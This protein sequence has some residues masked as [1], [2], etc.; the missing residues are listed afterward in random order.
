MKAGERNAN[1]KSE[2]QHGAAPHLRRCGAMDRAEREDPEHHLKGTTEIEMRF[3]M[4]GPARM[5]SR[6]AVIRHRDIS[7]EMGRTGC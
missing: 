7:P 3:A 5:A 6:Y 4:V 2:R 1:G